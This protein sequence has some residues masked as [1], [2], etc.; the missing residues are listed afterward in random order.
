MSTNALREKIKI[1]LTTKKCLITFCIWNY[2]LAK[3]PHYKPKDV[4]LRVFVSGRWV[5]GCRITGG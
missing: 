3:L 1:K 4:F 5:G 2:A